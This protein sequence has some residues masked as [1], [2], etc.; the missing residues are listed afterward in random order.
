M[1]IRV[2]SA[3][4]TG[5]WPASCCTTALCST[6]CNYEPATSSHN[7]LDLSMVVAFITRH[8][9]K[10]RPF[11]GVS[12]PVQSLTRCQL[13]SSVV[14]FV[15]MTSLC[16]C[17]ANTADLYNGCPQMTAIKFFERGSCLDEFASM[18]SRITT[19]RLVS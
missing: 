15:T 6:R 17:N 10:N 5:P 14:H 8:P 3:I 12:S 19:V 16:S 18:A 2:K 11:T 4:F 1:W 9:H 7:L 13:F